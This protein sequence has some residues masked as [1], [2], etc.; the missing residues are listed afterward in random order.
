MPIRDIDG[1][2]MKV[3]SILSDQSIAETYIK[4][5]LKIK[6]RCSEDKIFSMWLQYLDTFSGVVDDDKF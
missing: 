4:N 1:I 6:E 5:G 3:K 2:A